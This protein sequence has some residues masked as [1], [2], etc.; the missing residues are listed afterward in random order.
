M[1]KVVKS[2]LVKVLIKSTVKEVQDRQFEGRIEKNSQ[3][4]F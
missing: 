4:K 1:F 3:S 2:K